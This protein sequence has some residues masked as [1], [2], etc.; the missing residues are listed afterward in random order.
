MGLAGRTDAGV[1]AQG[2]VAALDLD[3]R[4]EPAEITATALNAHLPADVGDHCRLH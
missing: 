4:H 3:W 2:Q 1:H